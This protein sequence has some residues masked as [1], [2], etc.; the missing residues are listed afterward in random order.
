MFQFNLQPMIRIRKD[1][2]EVVFPLI[3]TTRWYLEILGLM[4]E[5]QVFNDTDL[6]DDQCSM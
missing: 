4:E 2:K 5:S 3:S 6:C 1:G